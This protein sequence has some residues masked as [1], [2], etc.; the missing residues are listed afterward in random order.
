MNSNLIKTILGGFLLSSSVLVSAQNI[1]ITKVSNGIKVPCMIVDG[2]TIPTINLSYVVITSEMI[3]PNK[4][5]KGQWDRL[6]YNVRVVLPLARTASSKLNEYEVVLRGLP[7]E[8]SRKK[9]L[10]Q[11]EEELKRDFEKKIK[12]LS[13]NQGMILIKLIDRETGNTSY[14]L[15]KK[16]RGNF[17]A[18]MWQGVARLFG[19]NL[20]SEYDS[21]GDDK[22]IEMAVNQI[23]NE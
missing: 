3:F 9:Y 23:E 1:P 4:R 19:S 5:K 6:K 21:D 16:L 11:A 15:V 7:D 20:K 10:E 22:L 12:D 18:F 17:K 8:R 14:D 13:F 2:D